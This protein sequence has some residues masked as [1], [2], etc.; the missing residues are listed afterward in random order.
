MKPWFLALLWEKGATHSLDSRR[1]CL[2]VSKQ[3]PLPN[4]RKRGCPSFWLA[5]T[6]KTRK[7]ILLFGQ[8]AQ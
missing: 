5:T 3:V 6:H 2:V 4:L 1:S 7:R 8:D